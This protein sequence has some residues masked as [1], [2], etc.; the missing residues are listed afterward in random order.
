MENDQIPNESTQDLTSNLQADFL[1]LPLR[2]KNSWWR[3][4]LSIF[5]ILFTWQV[6]GAIPY[7]AV[8]VLGLSKDKLV[9]F[10]TMNFSFIC[11]IASIIVCLQTFHKRRLITLVTPDQKI[12]WRRVW[13]SA[14]LWTLIVIAITTLDALIHPGSYRLT[15]EWKSWLLFLP[16]AAILTPIQTSAEE[17][18]FRGY[19]LQGLGFLTKNKWILAIISGV[20][21]AVPHFLNP[22]MKQGFV[23]LAMFYFA[24]GAILS[25]I[26][27]Q[28][29]RL[30]Y[31]LGIHAANNLFTVL[32]ANYTDSALPSPSIFT[33][34]I[35][36]PV[37]NL[38]SFVLGAGIIW[39]L[40]FIIW[41][42]K[43]QISKY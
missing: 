21:F 1:S 25:L 37:Y 23:L 34:T 26:T 22:E 40:L 39:L 35:L 42:Q 13:I 31:A 10:I 15:F 28:S 36:D 41:P 8:I 18:L 16:A 2:G 9:S 4:L 29:G 11:L 6:I 24:F 27:L 12:T 17:L 32:I 43:S 7:A 14:G 38:V 3:Y 30:D 5:I 20:I 19:F 33:A